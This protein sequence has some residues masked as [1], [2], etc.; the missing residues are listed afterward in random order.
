MDLL[1]FGP[2]EDSLAHIIDAVY[3]NSVGYMNDQWNQLQL[4]I[5]DQPKTWAELEEL[6]GA[7][8]FE[9]CLQEFELRGG[10]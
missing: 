9:A 10:P 4:P 8:G 3:A 7:S 6:I 2:G 1:I 5:E